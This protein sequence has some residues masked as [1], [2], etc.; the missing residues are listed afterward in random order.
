[1]GV[2]ERVGREIDE[3]LKPGKTVRDVEAAYWRMAAIG[4][5][6]YF[7]KQFTIAFNDTTRAQLEAMRQLRA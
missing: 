2:E 6:A 1:M 7:W 4:A 3:L 5:G